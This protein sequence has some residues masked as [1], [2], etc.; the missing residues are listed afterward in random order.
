MAVFTIIMGRVTAG[1]VFTILNVTAGAVFTIL[2]GEKCIYKNIITDPDQCRSNLI[3]WSGFRSNTRNSDQDQN[4]GFLSK[5]G[6]KKEKKKLFTPMLC[7]E[8]KLFFFIIFN[9]IY[10]RRLILRLYGSPFDVW[11]VEP[12]WHTHISHIR[13]LT[14]KSVMFYVHINWTAWLR[15]PPLKMSKNSTPSLLPP[16]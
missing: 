16:I 5:W 1:A 3:L 12:L 6:E 4:F 2:N 15:L 8:F 9:I 7:T 14:F 11:Y 13:E 10:W